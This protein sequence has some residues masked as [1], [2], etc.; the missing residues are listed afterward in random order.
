V[1]LFVCLRLSHILETS[2][3]LEVGMKRLLGWPAGGL[4]CREGTSGASLSAGQEDVSVS[5]RREI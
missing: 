3:F 1:G 2:S 4:R 5:E